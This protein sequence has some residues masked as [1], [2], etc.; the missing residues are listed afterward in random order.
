MGELNVNQTV[1]HIGFYVGLLQLL[2][3]LL[4]Y[5]VQL[6]NYSYNKRIM[7][8]DGT[9][10]RTIMLLFLIIVLSSFSPSNTNDTV[11]ICLKGEVYHSI[12]KCKGLS[13]AKS[14]IIAITKSEAETKY[15]RRPCKICY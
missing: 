10:L 5:L 14:K 6:Y 1:R 8:K 15:K 9:K 7:S 3:L 12:R 13:K 2:Y 4:Q 11:F